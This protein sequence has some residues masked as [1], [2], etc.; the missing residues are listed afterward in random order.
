MPP[1][2]LRPATA[3][4]TL[5]TGVSSPRAAPV[6]VFA[7]KPLRIPTT[8]Y[9]PQRPLLVLAE[10]PSP[11]HQG[12][13]RTPSPTASITSTSR[14]NSLGSPVSF[15]S[16]GL[17]GGAG[18]GTKHGW[19]SR[20]S[21]FASTTSESSNVL[22]DS[23]GYE[24]DGVQLVRLCSPS[25]DVLDDFLKLIHHTNPPSISNRTSPLSFREVFNNAG[26]SYGNRKSWGDENGKNSATRQSPVSRALARNPII[27]NPQFGSVTEKS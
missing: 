5:L 8:N 25:H 18:T 21:S 3:S 6:P 13:A 24:G 7:P 23:P 19:R 10:E 1:P 12:L 27:Y 9:F 17:G 26:P 15:P 22:K 11:T 2:P 16:G 4:P 20:S 14:K